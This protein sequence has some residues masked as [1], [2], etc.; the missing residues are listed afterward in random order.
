MSSFPAPEQ[1]SDDDIRRMIRVKVGG[2][3]VYWLAALSLVNLILPYV[4]INMVML[5]GLGT[6]L[7][8]QGYFQDIVLVLGLNA[9]VLGIYAGLGYF[10]TQGKAWAFIIGI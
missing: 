5:F 1:L 2:Q 4:H 3:W 9:L 6:S 7:M 8:I 10:A